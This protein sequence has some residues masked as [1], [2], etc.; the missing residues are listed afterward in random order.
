V[1][2]SLIVVGAG[3]FT[4]WREAIRQRQIRRQES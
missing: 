2:G 4:I 1:L 3:L